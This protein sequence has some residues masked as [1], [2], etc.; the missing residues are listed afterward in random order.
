MLTI[1]V[2]MTEMFNEATNEFEIGEYFT[3]TLEHS[4][5][6]LSKWES[7]YERP[8]LIDTPKTVEEV[9]FYIKAMTITPNVPSEVYDRL[10]QENSDDINKHLSAKMTA[11][12]FND[13]AEEK[14]REIITAELIYY[15]MVAMQIPFECQYWHLNK[16]LTLIRVV[17]MKNAP[18]KKMSS[19]EI[20][21]R[22]RELNAK[23]KA[24]LG[25]TG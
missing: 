11:T 4:L 18:K 25:T 13:G 15:W 16:L 17:N 7:F 22:N 6:S 9:I 23:R 5:S 12:W 20:A 2:P 8:F 1:E 19:G 24:A 14:S 3:L 10:S 21:S